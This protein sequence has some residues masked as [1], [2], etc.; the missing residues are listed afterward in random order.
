MEL[1]QILNSLSNTGSVEKTAS[2]RRG[3]SLE[4]A[5]DRALNEPLT[6]T[7]SARANNNS[8]VADLTKIAA[9]LATAEQEALI[10]EAELYGAAVCDGFMS[11]MHGYE[12]SGR[13]VKVASYQGNDYDSDMAKIAMEL[14]YQETKAELE[15]IASA[16]YNDGYSSVVNSVG[17]NQQMTKE[18]HVKL[19]SGVK[20]ASDRYAKAGYKA[21][22]SILANMR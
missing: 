4:D 7:A 10:K 22:M 20:L 6:K 17:Y 14:G 12:S 13:G 19:A 9:K 5:L 2:A 8:P 16:A 15:K 3:S 18:A 1:S 11:R 21:A